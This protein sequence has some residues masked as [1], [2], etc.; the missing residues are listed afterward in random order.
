[1]LNT[2][3]YRYHSKIRVF[4]GVKTSGSPPIEQSM[5]GPA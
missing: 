2:K 5:G 3:F 4:P 1:V